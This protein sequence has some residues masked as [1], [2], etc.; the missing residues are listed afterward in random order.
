MMAATR[1]ECE[2]MGVNQRVLL[3]DQAGRQFYVPPLS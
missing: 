2:R 3:S 1:D